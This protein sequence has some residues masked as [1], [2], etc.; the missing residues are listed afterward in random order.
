MEAVMVIRE[1]MSGG[2]I[3]VR[4]ETPVL[5]ARDLM[6]KK[7]IRHLLV[8]DSSRS[9][10]GIVTDRDIRLNL[11]SQAT[12]LSAWEI[13]H[14]LAKLTVG[15]VMTRSVVTVGPDRPACH[16]AQLMLDHKIGALPVLDD[17]LLIGIVTE[18]DIVRAFVRM[19][20]P[21]ASGRY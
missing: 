12:G 9:L 8:T 1:L 16:G 2:L 5:E 15:E 21:A 7:R 4:R 20:A 11:P 10:V 6:A 18:S 13:S 3:T 17:G 19:T 14:L